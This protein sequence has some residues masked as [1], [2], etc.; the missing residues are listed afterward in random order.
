MNT[1]NIKI[2]NSD[3]LTLISTLSTMITAGIPI[4]ETVDSLLEDSK[5]NTKKILESV[6]EDLVQGKSLYIAFSKF[7]MVFDKVAVNVIKASEE[8]GTLDIVLKDLKNQ[9]QKDIEFVDSVKASL[10]YPVVILLMFL[11]VLLIILV[12]V[13]P[14]IAKVFEQLRVTLPLPTKIMIFM[15][16][17]I[18][19]YSIPLLILLVATCAGLFFM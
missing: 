1:K 3:K 7:P 16:N 17:L 6:R 11:A 9:T 12:V 13:I 15:S 10:T 18:L 19:H 14:K 8:A 5:G 4:L 2:S